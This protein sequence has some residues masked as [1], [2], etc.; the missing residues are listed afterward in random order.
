MIT[1]SV[2]TDLNTEE[3]QISL[4]RKASIAKRISMLR[5]LSQTTIQLSRRAISRANPGLSEPEINLIFV[6]YH[7]GDELA[8]CLRA[9]MEKN[10]KKPDTVAALELVIEVFENLGIGYYIGGSVASSAYGIAR[11]TMDIDLVANLEQH[12]V[13]PLVRNLE[14]EYYIDADMITDAISRHSSFNII[15][16]ETMI[17][18]DVFVLKEQPYHQK[19]F[20]RRRMDTLDEDSSREFYLA[21]PEDIILNKLDWYR[22]GGGVSERQWLD[23]LGVLKV[24][25]D[26]LDTEYLRYWASQ[27][28]LSDLLN[29]AFDDAGI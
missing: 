14:S 18:V 2:D 10:M 11:A 29:Q 19:A 12:H 28:K 23:V 4:I 22:M 16:L 25:G 20:E 7:Y 17:K 1:Q 26:L 24:Q 8:N 21:S 3:T 15:H 27:L 13:E 9:Y 5:S 6:A